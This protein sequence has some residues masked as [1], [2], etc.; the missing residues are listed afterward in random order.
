MEQKIVSNT[1][2]TYFKTHMKK[3]LIYHLNLYFITNFLII[4]SL[5]NKVHLIYLDYNLIINLILK[6]WRYG[7]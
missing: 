2:N 6:L 5:L 4:F 7:T 3:Q 1:Q